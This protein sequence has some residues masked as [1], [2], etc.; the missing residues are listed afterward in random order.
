MRVHL[1][2]MF[3]CLHYSLMKSFHSLS[4]SYHQSQI[5]SHVEVW[6]EIASAGSVVC[7]SILVNLVHKQSTHSFFFGGGHQLLLRSFRRFRIWFHAPV[8]FHCLKLQPPLNVTAR[9]R[10]LR[11]RILMW[12]DSLSLFPILYPFFPSPSPPSLF[13]SPLSLYC[14][15]CHSY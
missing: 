15:S 13:F 4:V 6:C 5:F 14:L 9:W 12:I 8:Q 11:K 7:A 10:P 2:V 3:E 1:G